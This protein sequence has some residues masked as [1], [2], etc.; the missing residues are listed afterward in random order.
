[1]HFLSICFYATTYTE[2]SVYII[3]GWTG[4]LFTGSR[5]TVI[6]EYKD[7]KWSNV[8]NLNTSRHVHGAIT[9]GLWTMILG[10]SSTDSQP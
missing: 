3:G 8:G 7:E 4:D 10:G 2:D 1:M 9:S 6:A 5:T